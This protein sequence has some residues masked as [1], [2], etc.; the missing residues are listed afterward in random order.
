M[1]LAVRFAHQRVLFASLAVSVFLVYREPHHGM[2]GI[3]AMTGGHLTALALGLAAAAWLGSGYAAAALAMAGTIVVLIA[4]GGVHP[5]A[6]ATAL[7]FGF[8][9]IAPETIVVF[10]LCLA[11][12]AALLVLQRSLAR[13]ARHVR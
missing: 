12:L 5:P 11:G 2:N 13:I 10:V 8:G 9:A 4:A 7:A 1:A 3:G 6:I